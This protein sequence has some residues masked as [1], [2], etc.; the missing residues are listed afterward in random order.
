MK[1]LFAIQGTGNG[2]ISRARE[3]VPLLQQYG[4][5]DLLISGTEA[6]VGLSQPLKYR[7]H[8]FSFVFGNKGG[9][10]NW[11]TVKLMN[12]PRLI[13]DMKS[14]PLEQY[15]LIVNDFEPVSAWACKLKKIPCVSLSHQCSFVSPKTPRVGHSRFAELIFKHYSP[16]THHIG[17]H[18]ER[19]D[20]FIHTPVIRSEIRAMETD[21][22]DHYTVYL[23]AYDDKLLASHLKK[24]A[25]EWNVFSK[26]AKSAYRDGNVNIIPVNNEGFNKSLAT[27]QGLL[28]G[29]GFEGPAE[30]LFL[31]KKV[32]MIPMRGQYEQQ[33]N[34]LSASRLGV[35]VV[36]SIDQHF[37]TELDKWLSAPNNIKVNFP[38]ETAQIVD[39]MVKKYAR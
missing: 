29:G 27:G 4:D 21:N 28:T 12:L 11:A 17:F 5:L 38:D 9:V 23:P 26:R 20:D 34:A 37:S 19:Y 25:V 35:P 14:L 15:D 36:H 24:T 3:V 39:A 18:F 31:G 32:M 10:D 30:A 33:C 22:K 2:H 8:G 1:I 16:T 13:R 6:E 7:F